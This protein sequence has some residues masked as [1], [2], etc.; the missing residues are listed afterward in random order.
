M[1]NTRPPEVHFISGLFVSMRLPVLR[2]L[3][4]A[5][6]LLQVIDAADVTFNIINPYGMTMQTTG[7]IAAVLPAP[8]TPGFIVSPTRHG[9]IWVDRAQVSRI[10]PSV[11]RE[12]TLRA[13][14]PG[15]FLRDLSSFAQPSFLDL[16][17]L[18]FGDTSS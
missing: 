13:V 4:A 1:W 8:P 18:K 11:V 5:F 15:A 12:V 10:F 7:G 3:V 9:W 16:R 6:L 2:A 14:P 17:S